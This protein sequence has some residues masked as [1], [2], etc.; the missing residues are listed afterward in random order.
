MLESI[1]KEQF[2]G[3][4][5]DTNFIKGS[6]AS[7]KK[8]NTETAIFDVVTLIQGAVD[9]D[10][11]LSGLFIDL[12]KAFDTVDHGIL[13]NEIKVLGASETVANWFADYLSNR[14]QAVMINSAFSEFKQIECGVP[15]GS[16]LGPLLFSIFINDVFDLP[17]SGNLFM[18]ADDA[19]LFYTTNTH[20][21]LL[22]Q[23]QDDLNLLYDWFSRNKLTLKCG[24]TNFVIF[25]K[26]A[27]KVNLDTFLN[28][29]HQT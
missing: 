26:P 14:K 13:L 1:A 16:V 15:Q 4:L 2:P 5:K 27:V 19:S 18:F 21:E 10:K 25:S 20:I 6:T 8:S 28:Y 29:N 11:A 22:G 3:Y 12:K 23:M 24:K 7:E 9:S 17:L